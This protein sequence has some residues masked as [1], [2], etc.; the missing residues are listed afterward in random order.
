MF[1]TEL[2][3]HSDTANTTNMAPA[4]GTHLTNVTSALLKQPQGMDR[5]TDILFMNTS[6]IKAHIF[7]REKRVALPILLLY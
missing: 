7:F 6:E 2:Q 5:Q 4:A 1:I 3:G